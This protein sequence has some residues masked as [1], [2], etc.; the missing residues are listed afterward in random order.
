[1]R[2]GD[3]PGY[4]DT[5]PG[6][7]AFAGHYDGAG[8]YDGQCG[9]RKAGYGCGGGGVCYGAAADPALAGIGEWKTVRYGEPGGFG[10]ERGVLDGCRRGTDGDQQPFVQQ[11]LTD[12]RGEKLQKEKCEKCKIMLDKSGVVC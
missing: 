9:R 11:K 7:G 6:G 2:I 8:G 1:M 12:V 10:G 5:V 3:R 4:C